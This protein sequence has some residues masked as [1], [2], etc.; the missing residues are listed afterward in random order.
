VGDKLHG[1]EGNNPDHR[2][3]S[4]SLQAKWERM[5]GGPDSQEVGSE[6]AIL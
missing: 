5:W 4:L 2:L 6:A 1:R 3:R